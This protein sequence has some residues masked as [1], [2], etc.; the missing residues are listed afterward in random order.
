VAMYSG[1]KF[2]VLVARLAAGAIT[3]L[4]GTELELVRRCGHPDC[5]M[6]FVQQHHRRRFCH[7]SCAHRARQARY[8]LAR[9]A[10]G[11]FEEP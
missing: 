2:E 11:H 4:A 3:F 1:G 8:Y 7:E 9:T 6:F 5:Q 10:A